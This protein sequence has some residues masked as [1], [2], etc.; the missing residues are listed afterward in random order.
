MLLASSVLQ[1]AF[2]SSSA[3]FTDVAL[4]TLAETYEK[5]VLSLSRVLFVLRM[6][7]TFVRFLLSLQLFFF[8]P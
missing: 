7:E 4:P 8:L 5:V 3:F 6:S 2:L 1:L